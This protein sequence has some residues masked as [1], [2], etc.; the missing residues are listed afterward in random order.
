MRQYIDIVEQYVAENDLMEAIV[1]PETSYGYWID[2]EG[3]ILAV[4]D[5]SHTSII[6]KATDYTLNT[7]RGIR[8][9]WI[10][11]VIQKIPLSDDRVFSIQCSF[12]RLTAR[13]IASLYA[14]AASQSFSTY[15][16]S[17]GR[18]RAQY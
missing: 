6:M 10:R 8:N 14:I 5:Y 12:K 7:E 16:K 9:G 13:V 11:C 4:P 18:F 15:E 2:P 3:N 1:V 17:P